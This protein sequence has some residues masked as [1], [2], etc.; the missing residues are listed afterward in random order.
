MAATNTRNRTRTSAW[1]SDRAPPWPRPRGG[2][3]KEQTTSHAHH[4]Q[5]I[6][7]QRARAQTQSRAMAER[8]R[9][10]R[11]VTA[12]A[13]SAMP[14][15]CNKKAGVSSSAPKATRSSTASARADWEARAI[16]DMGGLVPR[17][18]GL[19][20]GGVGGT[21]KVG[22]FCCPVPPEPRLSLM[23][24]QR[25]PHCHWHL[26]ISPITAVPCRAKG[27]SLPR[28]SSLFRPHMAPKG[29]WWRRRALPPGPQRLFHEPFITIVG[30]L[31]TQI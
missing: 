16:S 15:A 8:A 5:P 4:A 26:W 20:Q 10:H 31:T 9:K 24:R 1:I 6:I 28:V 2:T 11:S 13:T 21:E 7:S 25:A 17:G 22:G 19:R 12:I 29:R 23:Q 3:G 30:K 18:A 14:W 27:G